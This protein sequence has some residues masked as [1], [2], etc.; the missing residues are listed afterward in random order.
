MING[1]SVLAVIPAR[2]GSKRLPRKNCLLLHGKPLVV[3]S[4]EAALKSLYI[5]EV[6][7]STDDEE[8]AN[9]ARLAGASVP[10]QRPAEISTDESASVDVVC[11]VINYYQENEGKVFDYVV[12]LQPTSPLRT[13]AHIDKAFA[14]L[15]EKK[16][17]AIISVCETEHSPLWANQLPPDGSMVQFFSQDLLGKRSQD[18]PVYYRL[19]GAIYICDTLRFLREKT[20]FI[21]DRI[22]AY[23]MEQLDSVDI[24]TELDFIVCEAVLNCLQPVDGKSDKGA[25]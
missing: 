6:L 19:N 3:Y 10:F 23:Q 24:D 11:H 4:I 16:A 5:D 25:C 18:L 14:L 13:A 9:V 8:I 20:F 7:V 12:L 2:G 1:K 17:D 21:A 22:F 15:A